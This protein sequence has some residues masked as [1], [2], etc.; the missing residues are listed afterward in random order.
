MY[1]KIDTVVP[2]GADVS[3]PGGMTV[4]LILLLLIFLIFLHGHNKEELLYADLRTDYLCTLR[5]HQNRHDC[6]IDAMVQGLQGAT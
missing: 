5:S 4:F 3:S 1:V 2:H 6:L